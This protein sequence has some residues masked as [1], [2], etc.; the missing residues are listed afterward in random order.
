MTRAERKA[1]TLEYLEQKIREGEA[2][3][4][5]FHAKLRELA[6][7]EHVRQF[8]HIRHQVDLAE[9]LLDANC[10]ERDTLANKKAMSESV[11]IPKPET[12][13]RRYPSRSERL[14]ERLEISNPQA[15]LD[16]ALPSEQEP[17]KRRPNVV[18][19]R[20]VLR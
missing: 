18:R 6:E 9:K 5:R 16:Q 2:K 19:R 14:R 20:S 1:R 4:S 10:R 3:V 15:L 12:E 11:E 8:L 13:P 7:N 17:E